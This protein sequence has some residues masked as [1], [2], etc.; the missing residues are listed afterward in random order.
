MS[1]QAK[2]L[3]QKASDNEYMHKDFH[4]VLCYAIKYLDEHFGQ[5][6]TTEY[7][8]QVGNTYFAPLSEQLK[9][10]GL[11]ALENHFR[12]IFE[13]ENG[14]FKI[15]YDQDILKI[16]VHSCPAI[17]HLKKNKLFFTDRFCESTV[18]VNQAICNNAGYS[19]SC[20]YQPG[21]GSCVQKFWKDK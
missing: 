6:S 4:G 10:Q 7:L 3:D 8:Q 5:E 17:S 12:K 14:S 9:K 19:S 1:E 18:I 15:E 21:K 16:T 13:K 20:I 2:I 11:C